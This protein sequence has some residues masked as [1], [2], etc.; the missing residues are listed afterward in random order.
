MSR[1]EIEEAIK[2]PSPISVEP[3]QP[4]R[5]GYGNGKSVEVVAL[6]LRGQRKVSKAY[7]AILSAETSK[8]PSAFDEA[9]GLVEDA[10]RLSLPNVSDEF[11]ETINSSMACEIVSKHL[12]GQALTP[13]DKKKSE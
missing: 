11:L 7:S 4:F 1:K 10:L 13:D 12:M 2:E 8:S 6:S 9:F 5:V 3:G